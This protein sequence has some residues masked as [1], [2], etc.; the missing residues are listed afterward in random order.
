[1]TTID[2]SMKVHIINIE[3]IQYKTSLLSSRF[4]TIWMQLPLCFALA[5]SMSIL[6]SAS[7]ALRVAFAG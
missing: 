4:S 2:L 5:Q 6:L 7:S 3:W 1:M